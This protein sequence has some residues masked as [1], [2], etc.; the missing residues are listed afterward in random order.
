MASLVILAIPDG[1]EALITVKTLV[2]FFTGVSSHMDQQVA[3]FGKDFSTVRFIAFEQVLPRMGRLNMKL[4][5]GSS[6]ERF[7]A[8]RDATYIAVDILVGSFMVL[9]VLLELESLPAFRIRALEN[10]VG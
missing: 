5:S 8:V 9:Q 10:S 4:K 6:T 2:R 1:S 7:L 3:L